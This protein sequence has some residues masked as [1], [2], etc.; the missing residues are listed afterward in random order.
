[1]AKKKDKLSFTARSLADFSDKSAE[2]T[3]SNWL[4]TSAEA[5]KINSVK[6]WTGFYELDM[7]LYGG[8]P[9]GK[10]FEV[11]G[12]D[13]SGKTLL[14]MCVAARALR[15]CRECVTPIMEFVDYETGDLLT[16]CRCH[17]NSPMNVIYADPENKADHNWGQINGWPKKGDPLEKH[18]R[19][20]SP[21]SADFLS[22]MTRIAIKSKVL[23]LL[24]ADSWAALFPES[25][26]GRTAME[27][28]PGDHA[29]AIQ[30]LLNGILHE[31]IKN[32]NEGAH[33]TTIFGINQIRSKIGGYG[34]PE[35][36]PGGWFLKYIDTGKG[37]M[38]SP[39]TNEGIQNPKM[40]GQGEHYVDF[41]FKL[42]KAAFGVGKGSVAGWRIYNR[43]Y[44]DNM[45]GD[46]NEPV[47][48]QKDLKALGFVEKTKKGYKLLGLEFPTV[49][50]M[51]KALQTPA[52][53]WA[54]RFAV[55]YRTTTPETRQYIDVNRF[56]YNPYYRFDLGEEKENADGRFTQEI[57]LVRRESPT[58][59]SVSKKRAKRIK[60]AIDVVEATVQK[61]LS[62]LGTPVSEGDE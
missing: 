59:R 24:V 29:K 30:N 43:R 38:L 15:T 20:G 50:T 49:T 51:V 35:T 14:A 26:E 32:Q 12:P 2:L 61:A 16:V 48:M 56:D 4:Q 58:K 53:Q 23:D 33:K 44:G 52:M 13:S 54:V 57:K 27:Q 17:K 41:N 8:V 47:R 55:M 3:G 62:E 60:K 10:F 11:Y 42:E 34:N 9:Y 19:V 46:T 1:M 5:V 21:S 37:R 18:F 36:T 31:N 22:D 28:Q 6:L 45:P 25:R 7:I 39:K 40:T